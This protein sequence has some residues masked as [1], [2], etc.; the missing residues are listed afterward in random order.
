MVLKPHCLFAFLESCLR[1]KYMDFATYKMAELRNLEFRLLGSHKSPACA[2]SCDESV[3]IS[4]NSFHWKSVPTA[5]NDSRTKWL[6]GRLS[7]FV[8]GSLQ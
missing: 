8:C 6:N 1:Q 3:A 5:T 7:K 4:A 2:D